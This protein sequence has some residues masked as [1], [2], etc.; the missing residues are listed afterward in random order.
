MKVMKFLY[1]LCSIYWF[2]LLI[3]F[4][5]GEYTPNNFTIGTTLFL[6]AIS[7]ISY[8]ENCK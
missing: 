4:L 2:V 3:L 5:I 6:S 8:R 1:G 7:F